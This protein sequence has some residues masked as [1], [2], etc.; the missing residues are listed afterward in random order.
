MHTYVVETQI[1]TRKGSA[2]IVAGADFA[3]WVPRGNL[4]VVPHAFIFIAH[5]PEIF[6]PSVSVG[7]VVEDGK[8]IPLD[9]LA[10]RVGLQVNILE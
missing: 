10:V 9:L 8:S 1:Q 6:S 3:R 2:F 5:P 7:T 4:F